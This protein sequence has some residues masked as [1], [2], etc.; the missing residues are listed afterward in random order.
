MR[1]SPILFLSMKNKENYFYVS[2]LGFPINYHVR[3]ED[4]DI[5][6]RDL[7]ISSNKIVLEI[8]ELDIEK[9]SWLERFI[10]RVKYYGTEI[11]LVTRGYPSDEVLRDAKIIPLGGSSTNNLKLIAIK[12]NDIPSHSN[13]KVYVITTT[14][15]WSKKII[16]SIN[17]DFIWGLSGPIDEIIR[18]G[19]VLYFDQQSR[20]F[21]FISINEY[22]EKYIEETKK[23]VG[24]TPQ[25]DSAT[26]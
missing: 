16:E 7:L 9:E 24:M 5:L 19:D 3:I 22:T 6:T 14:K 8:G 4:R 2:R 15:P 20:T 21:K 12:T 17:R 1:M 13:K 18:K 11:Y 26:T 23:K 10:K 25:K